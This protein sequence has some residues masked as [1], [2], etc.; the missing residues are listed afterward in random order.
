MIIQQGITPRLMQ[1]L[2]DPIGGD[3]LKLEGKCLCFYA[4]HVHKPHFV[5]VVIAVIGSLARGD[6]NHIKSLTTA[7]VIPF[8]LNS[9]ELFFFIILSVVI[10]EFSDRCVCINQP[11]S[12]R[13]CSSSTATIVPE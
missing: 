5:L 12:D 11:T 9:N 2:D 13:I 1:L 7:G 4:L 3:D 8:L 10:T 6:E